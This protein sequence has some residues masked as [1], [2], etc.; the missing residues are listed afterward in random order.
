MW[1]IMWPIEVLIIGGCD[2]MNEQHVSY[3]FGGNLQVDVSLFVQEYGVLVLLV[4]RGHG[5]RR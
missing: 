1:A 3:E 2:V 4:A 5:K